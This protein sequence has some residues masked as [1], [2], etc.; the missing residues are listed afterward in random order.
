MNFIDRLEKMSQGVLD[1]KIRA[2]KKK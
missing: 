1:L 2:I